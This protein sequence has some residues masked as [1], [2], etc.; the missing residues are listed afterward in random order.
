[1]ACLIGV[2]AVVV[3][4]LP[5]L[6]AEY[7]AEPGRVAELLGSIAAGSA[8]LEFALLPAVAALSDTLGRKPLLVALP[9]LTAA[10]RLLV[11][12]RPGLAA[13]VLSRVVVGALVTA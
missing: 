7:S 2:K 11:L 10:F 3:Q 8:M 4:A 12:L 13:L 1:M 9:A 5:A 6:L